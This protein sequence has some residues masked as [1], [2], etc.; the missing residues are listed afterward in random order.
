MLKQV[1][2]WALIIGLV[3]LSGCAHNNCQLAAVPAWLDTQQLLEDA[4]QLSDIEMSGR[5]PDTDGSHKAA[6]YIE[7][8]LKQTGV[9]PW[10]GSYRQPF[11]ESGPFVDKTLQNL[12]GYLPATETTSRYVVV[13]A[14]YDHLGQRGF[15]TFYGADDNASG[16]AAMLALAE[17]AAQTPKRSRH[18][19]FVASDGEESGLLGAK[20]FAQTTQDLSIDLVL[21]LD[22]LGRNDGY[23]KLVVSPSNHPQVKQQLQQLQARSYGCYRI[24]HP[25]D[26]RQLQRIDYSR[27][28][29]QHAFKPY[30]RPWIFV[31]GNQHSDWHTQ[32]DTV[33]R[34]NL[35]YFNL[36]T[37]TSW[38]LL[39]LWL[40]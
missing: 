14:H 6:G 3:S 26:R 2:L 31:G 17:Q 11:I 29:D 33:E 32:Y 4:T 16:V 24:G 25:Q 13:I 1:T 23:R 15:K 37:A 36:A 10:L 19:I 28:S 30:N 12:V 18:L 5:E 7:K 21:N 34:F 8:R 38:Q 9:E 39:N 20:H 40:D 27:S 35:D 22:M